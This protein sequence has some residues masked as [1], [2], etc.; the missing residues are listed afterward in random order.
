MTLI[1]CLSK[2]NFIHLIRQ[3][4]GDI[5]RS[6]PSSKNSHFLNETKSSSKTF[7]VKMRFTCTRKKHHLQINGFVFRLAS[8]Q[9]L[10]AAQKWPWLLQSN[11]SFVFMSL[12]PHSPRFI[13]LIAYRVF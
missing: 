10:G 6:F 13:A 3:N 11:V 5:K 4:D 9:W 2:Y 1:T 12:S 8:N 7:L